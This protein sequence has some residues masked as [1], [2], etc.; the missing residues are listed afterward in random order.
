MTCQ[1]HIITE[2]AVAIHTNSNQWARLLR[3]SYNMPTLQFRQSPHAQAETI[4]L[5]WEVPWMEHI[6]W[7]IGQ[8][9]LVLLYWLLTI[10]SICQSNLQAKQTGYASIGD[11]EC[12]QKLCTML[13]TQLRSNG[14]LAA[15]PKVIL[16]SSVSFS[17]DM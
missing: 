9:F 6:T 13:T 15:S 10:V 7:G 11:T 3:A 12:G 1:S 14:D 8:E 17:I 4:H 16:L 5:G 2:Y